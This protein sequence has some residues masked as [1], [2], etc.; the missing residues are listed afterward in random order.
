MQAKLE[1]KNISKTFLKHVG[2]GQFMRIQALN[3]VSFQVGEREFLSIIGPSGCGKTTLLRILDGL[4]EHDSGEVLVD[5]RP[6]TGP[7]PDRGMVFQT[8]NLFPWRDVVGNVELGLEIQGLP[9]GKRREIAKK[10]ID[11]V[12]LPG[13]EDHH[14]H[15]LSGGMQQR[16]GL[17][18]ALAIDPEILLM[19]EPFGYLDAQ[20]RELLQDELL[21]IWHGTKKA[22]VFVT[23]DIDE[24]VY[25]ADR[26][27]VMTPRPGTVR[28][29]I[30]VDLPRPRWEYNTR[31][32]TEF[33]KLRTHI[34]DSLRD[35]RRI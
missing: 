25:L 15:E 5:G 4:I 30:N 9:N 7:G 21:R 29:V 23:H 17:A 34:R 2:K 31:A 32:N 6:V 20:T 12:G 35:D 11:L 26:V 10:Y 33:V 16:V 18:R 28:E 24:A 13:F 22:V 3:D 8:F 1:V 14:P 27:I 19:D